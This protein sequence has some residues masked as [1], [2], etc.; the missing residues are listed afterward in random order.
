MKHIFINNKNF[1]D[2]FTIKI[3]NE[4]YHH[5]YRALRKNKNEELV[6]IYNNEKLI[7]KVIS[8]NKNFVILT[9]NKKDKIIKPNFEIDAVIPFL[10][11][12]AMPFLIEKITEAGINNI[13]IYQFKHSII[14]GINNKKIGRYK[15]IS[16]LSS[17]QSGRFFIPKIEIINN[18]NE[19]EAL[20]DNKNYQKKIVLYENA[21]T[22]ILQYLSTINKNKEKKIIFFSGPEGSFHPDEL[23]LFKNKSFDF[24]NIGKYILKAETAPVIAT[25]IFTSFFYLK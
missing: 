18:K 2:N 23:K 10:K 25:S 13:Y 5:L 7:L 17:Q 21:E 19:L 6:A 11:E 14:T 22:N 15:K 24:I 8:I 16:K 12:K 20:I 9:I 4:E 3:D 1:I